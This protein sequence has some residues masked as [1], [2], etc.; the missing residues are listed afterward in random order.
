MPTAILQPTT[1]TDTTLDDECQ[2]KP[3]PI[4]GNGLFA[5]RRFSPGEM[6]FH[7][8][9]YTL[10][11]NAVFASVRRSEFEHLLE[12]RAIRWTN[13]SCRSNATIAF[14]GDEVVI[15]ATSPIHE[16]EEITCDYF[17]TER[18]IPVP[19]VCNCGYC[20]GARIG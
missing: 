8:T 16:D 20:G 14:R 11:A 2:V 4:H 7:T 12:P 17:A 5:P 10:Y 15:V 9:G 6:I 18:G 19:F 3:S 13:H 1:P